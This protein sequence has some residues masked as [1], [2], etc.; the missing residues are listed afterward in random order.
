MKRLDTTLDNIIL[1]FGRCGGCG[2]TGLPPKSAP[3]N[4]GSTDFAE[5]HLLLSQSLTL[6]FV[7]AFHS[8]VLTLSHSGVRVGLSV[9]VA[10]VIMVD[11][12]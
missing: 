7:F 5:G 3:F 8:C 11:Y 10:I 2:G 1:V 12:G 4:L 6:S 9:V